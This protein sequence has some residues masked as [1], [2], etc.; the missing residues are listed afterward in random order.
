MTTR[1]IRMCVRC[2][3]VME[4]SCGS[5]CMASIVTTGFRLLKTD[6]KGPLAVNCL[7][8]VLHAQMNCILWGNP[9]SSAEFP[10]APPGILDE[11]N[12]GH[13]K[14]FRARVVLW[15]LI[16]VHSISLGQTLSGRPC[17]T[18]TY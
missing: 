8:G 14:S 6:L 11:T 10:P 15:N 17:R 4:T 16:G 13:F 1:P 12:N 2:S 9:S 5:I 18:E 3:V 7:Q